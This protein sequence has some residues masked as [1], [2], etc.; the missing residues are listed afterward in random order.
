[1]ALP[2]SL[3]RQFSYFHAQASHN[4]RASKPFRLSLRERPPKAGEGATRRELPLTL[5]FSRN[6]FLGYLERGR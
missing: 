4:P 3:S 6:V 1:M 2:F 5:V